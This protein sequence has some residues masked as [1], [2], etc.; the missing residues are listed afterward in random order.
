VPQVVNVS[1]PVLSGLQK[2][3]SVSTRWPSCVI[4]T[5]SGFKS[6]YTKSCSCRYSRASNSSAV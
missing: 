4:N 5:F 1:S 6:R 3:M 2:P